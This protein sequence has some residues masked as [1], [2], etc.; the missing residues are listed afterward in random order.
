MQILDTT[1]GA[2]GVPPKIASVLM[3]HAAPERQ[4]GAA[5]ITLARY[6]HALPEDILRARDTLA[7]SLTA[8]QQQ[9]AAR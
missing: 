6:T 3:G 5:Q 1:P 9:R 2:T 4:V 7:A 8:N